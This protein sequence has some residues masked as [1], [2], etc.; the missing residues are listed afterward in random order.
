MRD[1]RVVDLGGAWVN[2]GFVSGG[3][4]D[5]M[6]TLGCLLVNHKVHCEQVKD[7]STVGSQKNIPS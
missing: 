3:G 4:N 6:W 1:V 2:E 5:W 7:N